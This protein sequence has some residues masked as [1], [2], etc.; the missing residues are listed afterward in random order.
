[1]ARADAH[2]FEQP[3]GGTAEADVF[4]AS[5]ALYW[6][7]PPGRVGRRQSRS[8]S[9][10]NPRPPRS[11]RPTHRR[12]SVS[13]TSTVD[14]PTVARNPL[15]LATSCRALQLKSQIPWIRQEVISAHRSK[16]HR[17]VDFLEVVDLIVPDVVALLDELPGHAQPPVIARKEVRPQPRADHLH[18]GLRW[19]RLPARRFHSGTNS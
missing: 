9:S 11:S 3:I 5:S 8:T 10:C 14:A 18:E 19:Y 16:H 12:A 13:Q 2:L 17:R 4:E 15:S 1:M 7:S 6:S